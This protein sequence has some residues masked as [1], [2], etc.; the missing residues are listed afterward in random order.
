MGGI[1]SSNASYCVSLIISFTHSI[2]HQIFIESL[3]LTETVLDIGNIL[4]DKRDKSSGLHGAFTLYYSRG[5][6]INTLAYYILLQIVIID[7]NKNE[8]GKGDKEVEVR[9]G[10]ELNRVFLC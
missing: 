3:L 6:A 7:M 9:G 5:E 2:T 8:V 1:Y 10:M 4:G